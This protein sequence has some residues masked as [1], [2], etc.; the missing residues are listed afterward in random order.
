MTTDV[1]KSKV[2]ESWLCLF[3]SPLGELYIQTLTNIVNDYPKKDNQGFNISKQLGFKLLPKIQDILHP[4]RCVELNNLK[5]VMIFDQPFENTG[6]TGIP[7]EL[8][9]GSPRIRTETLNLVEDTYQL[10]KD[11]LFTTFNVNEWMSQGVLLINASMT[12]EI[13]NPDLH[14]SYWFKFTQLLINSIHEYN[15]N[16]LF[17]YIGENN[18]D[19]IFPKDAKVICTPSGVCKTQEE[20]KLFHRYGLFEKINQ[21]LKTIDESIS[22]NW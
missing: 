6:C 17:V 3:Q 8:Q 5:V 21:E 10:Y 14:I 18:Y 19:F 16:C 11:D 15:N 13:V 9:K 7:L 12:R 22:I 20:R 1:F 2:H 4:F